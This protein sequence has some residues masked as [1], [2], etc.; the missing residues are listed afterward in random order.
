MCSPYHCEHKECQSIFLV[1]KEVMQSLKQSSKLPRLYQPFF[2]PCKTAAFCF[3]G[4]WC[5]RHSRPFSS[6]AP[7]CTKSLETN[8]C[9]SVHFSF[10][11]SLWFNSFFLVLATAS[12]VQSI[13][14]WTQ[15]MVIHIFI[16]YRSHAIMQKGSKLACLLYQPFFI[17]WQD[18][19][20]CLYAYW[21]NRHS[22]LCALYCRNFFREIN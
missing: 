8:K 18:C 6:C 4:Y 21:C 2:T 14:L 3:Y 15:G 1:M 9:F 20:A 12:S 17:P 5:T 19:A 11:C 10:I 13:S 16:Y 22:I 7:Y